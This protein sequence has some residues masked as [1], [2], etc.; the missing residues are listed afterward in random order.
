MLN[1]LPKPHPQLH[2]GNTAIHKLGR[3]LS[4]LLCASVESRV[5]KQT[6]R[7]MGF[8]PANMCL[9]QQTGAWYGRTLKHT[10]CVWAVAGLFKLPFAMRTEADVSTTK[11]RAEALLMCSA[12]EQGCASVGTAAPLLICSK[13]CSWIPSV[14]FAPGD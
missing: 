4:W 7:S 5:C 12:Q 6:T 13:R 1:C 2:P 14:P 3:L 10:H 9:H 8:L 11:L